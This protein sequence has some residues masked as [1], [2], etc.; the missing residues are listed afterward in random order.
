M[1]TATAPAELLTGLSKRPVDVVLTNRVLGS[2]EGEASL[3]ATIRAMQPQAAIVL[4]TRWLGA[5]DDPAPF[6]AV[7]PTPYTVLDVRE[8]VATVTRRR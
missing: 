8:V 3:L 7:L 4:T 2:F 6:D 5:L 1:F